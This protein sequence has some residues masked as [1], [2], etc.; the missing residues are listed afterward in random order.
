MYRI[1]VSIWT[2]AAILLLQSDLQAKSI[3]SVLLENFKLSITARQSGM[4]RIIAEEGA[5]VS[6]NEALFEVGTERLQL[7]LHLATLQHQKAATQL[8]KLQKLALLLFEQKK[9]LH[10]AGGISND[11]FEI[12]RLEYELEIQPTSEGNVAI[13]SLAVE[14]KR[15]KVDLLKLDLNQAKY[16]AIAQGQVTKIY[17]QDKQRVQIGEKVMDLLSI[18]PLFIALNVSLTKLRKYSA[19]TELKTQIDTGS[20]IV[21]A[22]GILIYKIDELDGVD[23]VGR[24]L[25]KI[26]NDKDLFKPGM[27]VK[28]VLPY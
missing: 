27:R 18:N 20:G 26:N 1:I 21:K 10:E 13:A 12:A 8:Q 23:Q 15:I 16:L 25:I 9:Q 22:D 3:P 5:H 7:K 14:E 17:V 4:V 28:V 2:L 19:N 6:K 11:A 24:I